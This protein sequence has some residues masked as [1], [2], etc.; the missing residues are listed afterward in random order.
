LHEI[1]NVTA[2]SYVVVM[3][4]MGIR[5]LKK[6]LSEAVRAMQAGEH[7]LVT[8]RG[9]VV[10]ELVPAGPWQTDPK[11]PAGLARL[12]ERGVARLG[13]PNDPAMYGGLRPLRR[14]PSSA[15]RLLNEERGTQ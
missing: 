3:K 9:T 2:R 11:G 10:A 13:T 14:K 5:E 8:D 4:T 1:D 6:R 15:A 7:V 12:A